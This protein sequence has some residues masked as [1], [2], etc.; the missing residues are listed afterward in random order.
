MVLSTHA[1]QIVSEFSGNPK[2]GDIKKRGNEIKKDHDLAIELWSKGNLYSRLLSTLIFDSKLLT[3][4]YIDKLESDLLT[5]EESE[6][7][8]LGDWLLANQLSKDKKLVSLM[9]TWQ[10]N[11]SPVLRR[12]FWYYQARLRWTGRTPPPENSAEL[13]NSIESNMGTENPEVQW[14]M[15]FCAG[16]IG[17]FEPELRSRCIKIGKKLG[18]YRNDPVA[19]NCTP[20]YL[21]EFIRIESLKRE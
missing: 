17:V 19:K 6:R 11:A 21:P 13:L 8:Q 2:L 10:E 1:K 15:N 4:S 9:E 18:L 16:W 20:S 12:W 7:S 5:H 14:A 3:E